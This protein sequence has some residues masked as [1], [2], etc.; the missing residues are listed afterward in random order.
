MLQKKSKED[1]VSLINA[2]MNNL[3]LLLGQENSGLHSQ[4]VYKDLK[5]GYQVART[6]AVSPSKTPNDLVVP[7]AAS[8]FKFEQH[9]E[10]EKKDREL[11]DVMKKINHLD[12]LEN[13]DKFTLKFYFKKP[14]NP[15]LAQEAEKAAN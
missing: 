11:K 7:S 15:I 8:K 14:L 4:Q 13:L 5:T 9:Q 6:A 10:K 12:A 1:R 2:G 3:G